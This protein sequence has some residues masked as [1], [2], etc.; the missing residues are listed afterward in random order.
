MKMLIMALAFISFSTFAADLKWNCGEL[1]LKFIEIPGTEGSEFK[2]KGCYQDES[3]F[4]ISADC[5]KNP[6]EC[7]KRGEKKKIAHPG[8]GIGSPS[9]IQCYRVGGRPRFLQ[10]KVKE[11]WTDTATCFFGSQKSFMDFDT[12]FKSQK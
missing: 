7:L 3:L 4:L 10:V 1:S 8:G 6:K 11:K 2:E 9:F 5:Q 12:I